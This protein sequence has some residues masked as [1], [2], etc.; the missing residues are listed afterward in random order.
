MDEV[1]GACCLAHGKCSAASTSFVVAGADAGNRSQHRED[2]AQGGP[3]CFLQALKGI[4]FQFA[5]GL[6]GLP[7]GETPSWQEWEAGSG[8]V[9]H[10]LPA[11]GPVPTA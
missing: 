5:T 1:M 6:S 11:A 3:S 2:P 10:P 7:R 9:G 4:F 8:H